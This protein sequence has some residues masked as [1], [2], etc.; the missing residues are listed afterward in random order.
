MA[1]VTSRVFCASAAAAGNAR[2]PL[3]FFADAWLSAAAGTCAS[4]AA[5]AC[6]SAIGGLLADVVALAEL[7]EDL[8]LD[9]L[10]RPVVDG[11]DV[12]VPL[13]RAIGSRG[14]GQA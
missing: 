7:A 6:S 3:G 12:A 11:P 10:P 13:A 9:R 8:A 2:S 4:S 5:W 14:K 1:G